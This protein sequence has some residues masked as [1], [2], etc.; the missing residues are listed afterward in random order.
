MGWD[1]FRTYELLLLG[2]VPVVPAR[3]GGVH[4]LF[5]DLPVLQLKDFNKERTRAEY[6]Q[7][8]RE[9]IQSPAFQNADF[10]AGWKRV[11]LGHWRRRML[12]LARR[13]GDII[14]DPKTGREYYQGWRYTTPTPH[15]LVYGVPSDPS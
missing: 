4:G 10:E 1:C 15:P 5:D 9:Y 7:I 11:F 3:P 12:H 2:V 13:D 8:F 14:Q 6:L